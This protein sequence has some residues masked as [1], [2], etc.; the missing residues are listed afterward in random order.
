VLGRLP[1]VH[2]GCDAKQP[3]YGAEQA[4]AYVGGGVEGVFGCGWWWWLAV[5]PVEISLNKTTARSLLSS[6]SFL[7]S[8][9]LPPHNHTTTKDRKSVG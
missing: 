7:L 2:S 6:P 9:F 5:L 4:C 8:L 1:V 3:A